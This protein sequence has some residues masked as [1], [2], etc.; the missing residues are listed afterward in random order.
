MDSDAIRVTIWA[1]RVRFLARQPPVELQLLV[2]TNNNG[3]QRFFLSK[4]ERL[5]QIS[6]S[7]GKQDG[8]ETR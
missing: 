2:K 7:P 4:K 5:R 6:E 8:T 1:T 3:I